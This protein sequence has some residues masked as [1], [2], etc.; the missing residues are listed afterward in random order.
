MS[1]SEILGTPDVGSS[2]CAESRAALLLPH[3]DVY[4][5][6]GAE[7]PFRARRKCEHWARGRV[8]QCEAPNPR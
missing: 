8:Y 1:K 3:R 4:T 7:S 6:S 5:Y 2:S